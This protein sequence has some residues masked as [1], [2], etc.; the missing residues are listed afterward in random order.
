MKIMH[1]VSGL[2]YFFLELVQSTQCWSSGFHYASYGVSAVHLEGGSTPCEFSHSVLSY[3]FL[4]HGLHIRLSCTSATP[5]SVQIHVHGVGDAIQPHHLA[6]ASGSLGVCS[7]AFALCTKLHALGVCLFSLLNPVLQNR[8]VRLS[9]VKPGHDSC[10][11]CHGICY[12][13]T[14]YTQF[15]DKLNVVLTI[16]SFL[17]YTNSMV[18]LT[19]GILKAKVARFDSPPRSINFRKRKLWDCLRPVPISCHP[20]TSLTSLQHG[21][22]QEPSNTCSKVKSVPSVHLLEG[23]TLLAI[24]I[25]SVYYYGSSVVGVNSKSYLHCCYFHTIEH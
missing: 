18:A 11:I 2:S 23:S 21:N 25:P 13:T 1:K 3:C 4:P 5:G 19:Y 20:L 24:C 15:N 9:M 14:V 22:R 16:Y 17:I 7:R 8:L 6:L 12:W 10:R